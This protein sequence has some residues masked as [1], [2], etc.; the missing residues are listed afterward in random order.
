METEYAKTTSLN[1]GH[2]DKVVILMYR[3][4]TQTTSRKIKQRTAN[5]FR[6]VSE[7]TIDFYAARKNGL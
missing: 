7:K 3:V 2:Q 1:I 6:Y 5:G 4:R